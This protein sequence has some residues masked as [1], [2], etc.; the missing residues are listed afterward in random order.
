M[1]L[2]TSPEELEVPT[3]K[4]PEKEALTGWLT[5]V[6]KVL[7]RL[8]MYVA[9]ICLASLLIVVVYGVILRYVF[10]DAPPYVEQVALLLIISVAMFGASAGVRDAG[11]IGMDSLVMILPERTQ[12]WCE[13]I[14][15]VLTIMFALALLAGGVEMG[16]STRSDTIPTLG[17][18]EAIRY[19]PIVIAGVLITLFS[20]EH[21]VALFTGKEV[22]PSWH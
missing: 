6:N 8:A 14:V 20:I 13:V 4:R 5:T 15:Y 2:G 7:F 19:L 22:V 9:C 18:S 17:I 11:H 1:E 10:N 21:L 16:T 3:G 12:F